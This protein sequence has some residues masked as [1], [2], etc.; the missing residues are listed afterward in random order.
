MTKLPKPT[1]FWDLFEDL[2]CI[3]EVN[4]AFKDCLA[5]INVLSSGF[6]AWNKTCRSHIPST[7]VDDLRYFEDGTNSPQLFSN[8]SAAKVEDNI[9]HP[10]LNEG[11]KN[12][13]LL[14]S[15]LQ[16]I[17]WKGLLPRS[18]QLSQE[19]DTVSA[20]C[21]ISAHYTDS[22]VKKVLLAGIIRESLSDTRILLADIVR[23]FEILINGITPHL[24]NCLQ[25]LTRKNIQALFSALFSVPSEGQ[26]SS[27]FIE[28]F[29]SQN[30]LLLHKGF[31]NTLDTVLQELNLNI[32]QIVPHGTNDN[33][34]N[35]KYIFAR[36]KSW[37]KDMHETLDAFLRSLFHGVVLLQLKDFGAT[38][39]IEYQLQD[40]V[41]EFLGSLQLHR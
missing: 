37:L 20:Q 11:F 40:M 25:S 4:F 15:P 24:N 7:T 3:S 14:F 18:P 6:K 30:I 23:N 22:R 31:L 21:P 29:Q 35:L 9:T 28:I 2:E 13:Y 16:F 41:T 32:P 17:D 26:W 34:N 10:I 8:S 12:I 39:E 1:S 5:N 38:H 33:F 27:E 19:T 36:Y